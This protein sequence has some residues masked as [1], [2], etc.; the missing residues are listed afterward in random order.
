[1]LSSRPSFLIAK[2]VPV[3]ARCFSS[4]RAKGQQLQLHVQRSFRVFWFEGEIENR[5]LTERLVK[6][7]SKLPERC[8]A[9]L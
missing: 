2:H 8:S 5:E 9:I 7:L 4:G 6:S 1:L 3:H